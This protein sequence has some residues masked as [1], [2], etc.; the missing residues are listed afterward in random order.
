M[1]GYRNSEVVRDNLDWKMIELF[2][3]FISHERVVQE[4]ISRSYAKV[5][6]IKVDSHTSHCSED[7]YQLVVINGKKVTAET[8]AKQKKLLRFGK[9][10]TAL[11][12]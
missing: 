4:T 5:N 6:S 10:T 9:K 8:L 2:D 7:F 3:G 11:N 12:Q 1:N